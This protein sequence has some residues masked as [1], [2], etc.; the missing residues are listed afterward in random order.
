MTTQLRTVICSSSLYY[1][2]SLYTWDYFAPPVP[3][4]SLC[5]LLIP[6]EVYW[7]LCQLCQLPNT[8]LAD[9]WPCY[10]TA[11]IWNRD[12]RR[13]CRS[14]GL[15]CVYGFSGVVRLAY[16]VNTITHNVKIHW[17]FRYEKFRLCYLFKRVHIKCDC[18]PL[19]TPL[20][21]LLLALTLAT[22]LC[23][24][25]IDSGCG[26]RSLTSFKFPLTS[27]MWYSAGRPSFSLNRRKTMRFLSVILLQAVIGLELSGF[28][29]VKQRKTL[30]GF[31]TFCFSTFSAATDT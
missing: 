15:R 14:V 22:P 31:K 24:Y 16:W 20:S 11:D 21:L 4:T 12:M 19:T 3:S 23:C 1:H 25:H 8:T 30:L 13:D 6:L 9:S 10:H 28:T 29:L 2:H 27:I 5:R 7:M 26:T 18:L 17:Q